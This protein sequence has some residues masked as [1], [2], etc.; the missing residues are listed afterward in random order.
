MPQQQ[1]QQAAAI[2]GA[3]NADCRECE[4]FF[5]NKFFSLSFRR[6]NVCLLLLV[7]I[8]YYFFLFSFFLYIVVMVFV[9]LVSCA[10][11][12]GYVRHL[13]Q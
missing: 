6:C 5:F 1:Q 7:F 3:C 9:V 2:A 4:L 12:S 10:G 13:R 11:D 8:I